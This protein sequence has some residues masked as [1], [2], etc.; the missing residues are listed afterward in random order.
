MTKGCHGKGKSDSSH[1]GHK[2]ESITIVKPINLCIPF[3]YQ[4]V[5]KQPISLF[6]PTF[7]E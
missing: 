2:R 6:G 5:L 1:F 7:M 4:K 3:G